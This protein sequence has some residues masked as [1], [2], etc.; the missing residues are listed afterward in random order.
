MKAKTVIVVLA[1]VA[2]VMMSFILLQQPAKWTVPAA[3]AKTA[4]P[5]KADATSI[6][7]G[8]ALWIEHCESC[9]G[10]TGTGNGKKAAQLETPTPDLTKAAIQAANTDGEW[11]Y[12]VAEG[13]DD[14]PSF[15]KKIPAKNDIWNLVNYMRSLK[16]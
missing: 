14:M 12:K 2:V 1:L 13:R 16:K 11:F 10:K 4:N 6:A 5:V 7:D 3:N 9:H 15:K 8:K